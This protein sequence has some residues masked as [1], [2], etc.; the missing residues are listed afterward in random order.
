MGHI[1]FDEN[2]N[3]VTHVKRSRGRKGGKHTRFVE[4]R[5]YVK[6]GKYK[7]KFKYAKSRRAGFAALPRYIG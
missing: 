1:R 2:G 7:G 6:S 3:K 5:R 4:K